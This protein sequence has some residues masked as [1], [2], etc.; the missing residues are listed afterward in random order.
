MKCSNGTE[1][2]GR[3]VAVRLQGFTEAGVRTMRM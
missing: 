2:G 3:L 1:E